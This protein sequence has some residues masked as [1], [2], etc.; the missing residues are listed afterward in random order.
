[1]IVLKIMK[2]MIKL[3]AKLFVLPCILLI[4]AILKIYSAVDSIVAFIIGLVNILVVIGVAAAVISDHN[5]SLLLQAVVFF[6]SRGSSAG[7]TADVCDG[8]KAIKGAIDGVCDC[9]KTISFR[10]SIPNRL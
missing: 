1:M 4:S 10:C 9:L 5:Y 6:W 3:L 2:F 7:F 8:I